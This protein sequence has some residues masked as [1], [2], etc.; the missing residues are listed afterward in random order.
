MQFFILAY[1][2]VSR[3]YTLPLLNIINITN[4]VFITIIGL[5]LL[6]FTDL[7]STAQNHILL[8]S[9]VLVLIIIQV[10]TNWAM[11]L[12]EIVPKM[13]KKIKEFA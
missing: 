3:P 2:I 6:G 5:L 12:V 10:L 7:F 8:G 9:S 11:M 4:E 1:A 13:L